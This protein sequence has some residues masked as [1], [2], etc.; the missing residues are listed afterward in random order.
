MMLLYLKKYLLIKYEIV[1]TLMEHKVNVCHCNIGIIFP[2]I[3][4][5]KGVNKELKT[6]NSANTLPK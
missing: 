1:N 4:L 5:E 2:N 6:N 3:K